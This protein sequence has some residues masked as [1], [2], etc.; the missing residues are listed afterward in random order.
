M[1]KNYLKMAW[2][3]IVK[4]KVSSIINIGGLSVGLATAIVIMLVIVNEVSYDKF[5]TNLGDIH[6]LM[7]N[8]N[9]NGNIITHRQTPGPLAASV[10]SEIPEVKF[11]ARTNQSGNEL[12]RNG[13]K[14]I[15][16]NGIYTDPD[17]FRMMTFASVEGNPVA[18]LSEP[19]SI[20]I[21]ES[22]ARK[23]FG[24]EEPIGKMLVHNNLHA[25]KV[26]AVIRDIPI[27]STNKFDIVLPF[28][29]LEQENSWVEKWDNFRIQTWVQLQPNTNVKALDAK[30]TQLFLHKQEEKNMQLFTYPFADLRLHGNF[31]NGQPNG[32]II[33]IIMILSMVGLFVLLVACV[34][35]MNLATARSEQ[36]AKEVGVRKVLG[37]SRKKVILQFMLEAILMSFLALLLGVLLSYLALPGFMQLSG[38]H[39]KP[40]Y[41]NLKI[42]GLLLT[43]GLL[44]GIVAGSY[45]ALYLSRFQPVLV[46]K[47]ILT[48]GKG[49]GILRKGLV[50][51]QFIVSIFLIISTIVF[52]KQIDYMERRPIGYNPENLI[53]ISARDDMQNKFGIVRNELIQI[54]GVKSISAGNDDL[55][56]FGGAFNGLDWPGKTKDQ[57][58][59][60]TSTNVQYDWI[61]TVGLSLSE[62]RDFSREYGAD[63]LSCLINEAA[64][65]RMGLK[66]P[67]TGTKLGNNT[68]I[69]VV[70]DFVYNNSSSSVEPMIIYLNTG[71]IN[72]FF[73]RID[74][75]DNWKNC[76]AQIE[77]VVKKINPNIPLDFHFT[78]EEYQANFTQIRSI[79]QMANIFGGMAILISCLGLFGLSS[80]LAERRSKELS[81]RKVLGAS[82]KSIWFAISKDFLKPVFIAFLIA[83]PVAGVVISK[84]LS[85]LDYHIQLAWWMFVLSGML[86][87]IIAIITVSYNGI[88]AALTN[89]IKNLRTE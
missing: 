50:T 47:G 11:V 54:P 33:Y 73:V 17:F 19:G 29:L 26:A 53:E 41:F 18:A 25:L 72:H 35:F 28:R 36:R 52:F 42:W 66:A 59:Y 14:S 23:L 13:D 56:R 6:L 20:V 48:K 49:G 55:I 22:T 79:S 7:E 63:S 10:I 62:G 88:K 2:R 1:I 27:N 78:K 30:L 8:Q 69:G 80:Y 60:I 38:N 40:D 81:V 83:A 5:N 82:V 61:K 86:A 68:V 9:M 57:D 24:R 32:G 58:F 44:T 21:T 76:I 71:S 4:N 39:F 77:T 64:A 67:L 12:L 3:N 84:G 75:N 85:L 65:R 87:M 43:L 89:P 16:F 70:K 34:N 74:N 37:A 45:P 51:F 46:L 31:K 15:Y